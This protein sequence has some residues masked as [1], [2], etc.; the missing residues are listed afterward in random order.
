M[1]RMTDRG[2]LQVRRQLQG[3]PCSNQ[4]QPF[5]L[6][7]AAEIHPNAWH[8]SNPERAVANPENTVAIIRSEPSDLDRTAER[9]RN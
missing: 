9:R 7:R 8:C 4:S 5:I 6:D 3:G 2:P 1:L